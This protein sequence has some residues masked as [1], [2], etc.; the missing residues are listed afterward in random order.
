MPLMSQAAVERTIGK[1]VTDEAFRAR[2]FGN[3]A[4]ATFG[5]GLELSPCEVEALSRLPL[6]AVTRFSACVDARICR[7]PIDEGPSA[8]G[9]Q[10]S[11]ISGQ[12]RGTTA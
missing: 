11:T 7:L 2:F 1:L 12:P 3:P 5:A 8:D 10:R 6:E 4:A 9:D